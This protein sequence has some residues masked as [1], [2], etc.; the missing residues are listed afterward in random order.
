MVP[1]P[2]NPTRMMK[3]FRELQFRFRVSGFGFQVSG[4][5]FEF[6]AMREQ[7]ASSSTRPRLSIR[8]SRHRP[9]MPDRMGPYVVLLHQLQP[10]AACWLRRDAKYARIITETRNTVD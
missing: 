3:T 9:V 10:R 8:L 4:F 1:R 7:R 2:M 5:R 6:G